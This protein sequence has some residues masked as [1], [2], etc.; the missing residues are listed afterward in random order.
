MLLLACVLLP[1]LV[2]SLLHAFDKPV[3]PSQE[4]RLNG[5]EYAI[6]HADEPPEVAGQWQSMT[7]ADEPQEVAGQWQDTTNL[8]RA[9]A[10]PYASAWLRL[11]IAQPR[12]P[13]RGDPV[14][15]GTAG[16]GAEVSGTFPRLTASCVG[17]AEPPSGIVRDDLTATRTPPFGTDSRGFTAVNDTSERYR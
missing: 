17:D 11:N 14:S 13:G 3:R 5:F 9:P 2:L 10:D 8:I 16:T 1:V 12:R 7:N 15:Y 4:Y 6:S